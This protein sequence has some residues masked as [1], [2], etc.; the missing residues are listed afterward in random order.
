MF[1]L[2]RINERRIVLVLCVFAMIR[3]FLLHAD[4][5]VCNPM[6]EVQHFDTIDRYSE[7]EVYKSGVTDY[8]LNLLVSKMMMP[9]I[10][11]IL[12]P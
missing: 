3:V 11:Q 9:S 10:P 2:Q 4:F 5:P 8:S 1:F 6:D 12:F 7:G